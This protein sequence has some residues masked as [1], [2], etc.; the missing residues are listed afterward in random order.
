MNHRTTKA[1]SRSRN[2]LWAKGW[3]GRLLESLL[4]DRDIYKRLFTLSTTRR[5]ERI[6]PTLRRHKLIAK[7]DQNSLKKSLDTEVAF[8]FDLKSRFTLSDW[9]SWMIKAI[10]Y[11][12]VTLL[13]DH[14]PKKEDR[15]STKT[16]TFFSLHTPD[17]RKISYHLWQSGHIS[18]FDIINA[19]L[20]NPKL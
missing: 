8:Y 10:H 15:P 16:P 19:E 9:Y 17:E 18:L 14:E 11:T 13:K 20:Q 1:V 7:L 6:V 12:V 3:E 5:M 2:F 4:A